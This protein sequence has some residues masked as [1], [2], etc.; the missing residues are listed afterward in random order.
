MSK[1]EVFTTSDDLDKFL[2]S[3]FIIAERHM[4]T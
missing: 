4:K 2:I 3:E 1:S